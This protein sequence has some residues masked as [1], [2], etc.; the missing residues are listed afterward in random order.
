MLGSI[1]GDV[2][3]LGRKRLGPGTRELT[4][5]PEIGVTNGRLSL[6]VKLL[7]TAELVSSGKALD[8]RVSFSV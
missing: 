1:L 3:L 2:R 5:V 7:L 4:L 6:Q 8:T